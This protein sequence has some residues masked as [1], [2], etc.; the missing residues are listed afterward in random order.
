MTPRSFNPTRISILPTGEQRFDAEPL[1]E[2]TIAERVGAAG[3]DDDDDLD[4]DAG[5]PGADVVTP[6]E[7]GDGE[8]V[9]SDLDDDS[10]E[11]EDDGGMDPVDAAGQRG[12]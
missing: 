4:F 2:E 12:D 8:Q 10:D 1:T 11:D 5:R 6:D 3:L 7:L 9:S